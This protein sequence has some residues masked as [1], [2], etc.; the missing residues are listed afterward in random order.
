MPPPGAGPEAE[1]SVVAYRLAQEIVARSIADRWADAKL[2]WSLAEVFFL[3]PDECGV[4]L[5]GHFPIK[6]C[7]VLV[8]HENGTE[9]TVGNCCVKKF[10]DLP[11]EAIFRA[12]RRVA[13][14][15][16]KAISPA[17]VEHFHRRGWITAWERSFLLDTARKR[18]PS[19]K[20]LA[21]RAEINAK[22]L[23]LVGQE[24]ARA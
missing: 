11:S 6:E 1:G 18:R 5:C 13:R 8:N 14:D 10:L 17:A 7:C 16:S 22:L 2:E 20:V 21:K 9:V 24:V 15:P 4:C 23:H 3:G 19:P 12:L